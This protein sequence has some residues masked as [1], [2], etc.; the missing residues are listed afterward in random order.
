MNGTRIFSTLACLTLTV[1]GI[2]QAESDFSGAW[3]LNTSKG[4][5]L[6][7]VAAIQ[8]TL[9]VEQTTE[10]LSVKHAAVFQGK[11]STREVNYDLKGAPVTNYAA[12]GD[13]SET[14]SEWR[15][16][17][18]LTTWSSEGAIAGT[19]V[20]RTETRSLAEDGNTMT[21]ATARA[22]RPPMVLV[23]ERTE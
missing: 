3:V 23:Y 21:V 1:P 16:D 9:T 10:Q 13:K 2:A 7:M 20:T 12:M 22:D 6:G 18:L 8:E 15:G 11:E 5:N 4:E 17:G 19:T 14:V